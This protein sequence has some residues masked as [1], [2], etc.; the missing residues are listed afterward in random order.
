M[1]TAWKA[2]PRLHQNIHQEKDVKPTQTKTEVVAIFGSY[3]R[4]AKTS[5]KNIVGFVYD[6][7]GSGRVVPKIKRERE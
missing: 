6:K 3:L 7:S 5:V 1:R 4:R 2:F